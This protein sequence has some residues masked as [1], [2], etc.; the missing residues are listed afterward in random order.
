MSLLR[1]YA[2]PS[3]NTT[4]QSTEGIFRLLSRMAVGDVEAKSE[5]NFSVDFNEVGLE[6]IW[7]SKIGSQAISTT[8]FLQETYSPEIHDI[9]VEM[10]H[11][12]CVEASKAAQHFQL[13]HNR[14]DMT[15]KTIAGIDD[16]ELAKEAKAHLCLCAKATDDPLNA[17]RLEAE[18]AQAEGTTLR[19]QI[20]ELVKMVLSARAERD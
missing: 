2:C 18:I 4:I 15:D 19:W 20:G 5:R 3:Q 9:P 8:E 16:S 14:P 17:R 10:H 1:S 13:R 6:D 12:V 7:R 11:R